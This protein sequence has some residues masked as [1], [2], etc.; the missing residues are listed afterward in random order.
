MKRLLIIITL[1]TTIAG[2][3]QQDS[4]RVWN[5]W[6]VKADTPLL[7]ATANNVIMISSHGKKPAELTIKSLDN[8]LKLGSAEIKGDTTSFMAM[9]YPKLG[10]KMRLAVIDKKTQKVLRTVNF[11]SEEA[12]QPIATLGLLNKTDIPRKDVLA[13]TVL[14][15]SFANSMYSY[16]YYIKQYTFK[17]RIAGKDI[18]MPGK[19]PY[20]TKEIQDMI[21]LAPIGT[22][23]EFVDLKATCHECGERTLPNL[24]VWIR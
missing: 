18:L 17:T 6:C 19:G 16:P 8:A 10:K 21:A 1:L 24:R 3:A 2:Y 4:I 5:K 14:R 23:I 9:P 7:F 13:Q 11:C 22:L 15:V 12:P 20:I